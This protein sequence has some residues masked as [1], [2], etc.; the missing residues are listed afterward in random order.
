MSKLAELEDLRENVENCKRCSLWKTRNKAV[1]G[2]GPINAKIFL[3]GLGPGKEENLQGKPFVGPAGKFLNK[4]LKL[5]GIERKRVYITSVLKCYLPENKATP[6]QIKACKPY[7][8]KQLAI[9][10]PKIIIPLGSVAAKY[11]EKEFALEIGKISEA[12]AKPM[13]AKAFWGKVLIIPMYHPAA[14]LRNGAL[15]RTIEEDWK[16]IGNLLK[17][18]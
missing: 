17:S 5:A 2:E 4:L 18:R 6:Q 3:I 12:H 9:I 8:D 1:F 15:R 14:A 11:V 16:S 7:L 13:Q 10:K